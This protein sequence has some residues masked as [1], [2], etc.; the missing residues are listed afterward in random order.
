MSNLLC[1]LA[2]VVTLAGPSDTDMKEWQARY[3]KIDKL[4]SSKDTKTLASYLTDD[5]VY[6]S[7]AGKKIDRKT[8]VAGFGDFAKIKKITCTQKVTKVEAKGQAVDVTFD[9]QMTLD[10]GPGQKALLHSIAIDSWKKVKG[11]WKN[12]K[13]VEKLNEQK[14]IK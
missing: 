2:V 6:V 9:S 12:F 1:T 4:Y 3:A 14:T 5:F 13:T 10:N 11:E 7:K 8:I